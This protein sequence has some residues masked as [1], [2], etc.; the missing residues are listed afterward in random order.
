MKTYGS[1]S[2][3][4]DRGLDIDIDSSSNVY[5]TG[6]FQ[7]TVDFGSG[8]ITSAGGSDIFAL[9]LDSSGTFQCCLLYTSPSP[10]DS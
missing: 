4:A 9:K 10:R 6:Y 1:S 8:N 2:N 5:I 3:F 7:Q